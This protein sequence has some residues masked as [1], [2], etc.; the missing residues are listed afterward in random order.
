MP[1]PA[2]VVGGREGIYYFEQATYGHSCNRTGAGK[3]DVL[4]HQVPGHDKWRIFRPWVP[5]RVVKG[6]P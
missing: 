5:Q 4:G 2:T 1:S 6:L 3:R